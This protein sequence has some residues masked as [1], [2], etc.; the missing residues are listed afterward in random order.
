MSIESKTGEY[1][2]VYIDWEHPGE[3]IKY[4]LLL[5]DG[6]PVNSPFTAADVKNADAAL[7][8]I[9]AWLDSSCGD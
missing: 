4:Q 2:T 8:L 9:D 6:E 3:P 7:S 5:D 1:I